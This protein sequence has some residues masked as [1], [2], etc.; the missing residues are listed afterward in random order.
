VLAQLVATAGVPA[1]DITVYD[2]TEGRSI[3]APIVDK[4][5][6][7]PSLRAVKFVVGPDRGG[8]GRI[9][10]SPDLTS[11]IHFAGPGMEPALLAAHRQ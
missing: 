7:N 11:A 6:A 5:R 10:A 1:P 9:A 8:D 3:G 2:A 4:V